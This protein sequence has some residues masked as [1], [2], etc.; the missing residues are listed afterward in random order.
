MGEDT[1]WRHITFY[2]NPLKTPPPE[3]VKGGKKAIRSYF[4]Q[5]EEQ[6]ED[7]LFEAKMLI[8]GEPGAGKTSL[9]WKMLDP[10]CALPKE[11]ETTRGID[12]K[13]YYFPLHREDFPSFK[14]PEK[15]EGRK[16]R[17]NIWDFGGQ[18]IYKATHRF[19]LRNAPFMPLL[20]TAAMRTQIS[21]TGFILSRCS[22]ERVLC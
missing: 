11:D 12:V 21:I 1:L 14:R 10:D 13:G 6:S 8:L 18:E 22:A 16:F 20:Q 5:L 2:D 17:L 4:E 7:Y 19:F 3:I 9:T 15:L